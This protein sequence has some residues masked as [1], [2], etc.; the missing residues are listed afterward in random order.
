MAEPVFREAQRSDLE[1]I[2][3]LLW[4]DVLGQSREDA[5]LPLR[6]EYLD[7][8][9]DMAQ[10]P[11]QTLVVMEQDRTIVGCLQVTIIPG[12]SLMGARRGQIEGVHISPACQ[13]QGL[14]HRL[15]Q[16]AVEQCREH[17]CNLVQLTAHKSR[18]D[19]HRFYKSLGFE[20]THEGFKLVL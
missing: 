1:A 7:A 19:A 2:V 13:G 15:I 12:L 6:Q 17:G 5:S 3:H 16:W 20:P 14:G 18:Q 4:D 10:D 8:F 11:N 9:N